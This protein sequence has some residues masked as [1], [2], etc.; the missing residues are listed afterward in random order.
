[1]LRLSSRPFQLLLLASLATAANADEFDTFKIA[2]T[3]QTSVTGVGGEPFPP[4][5]YVGEFTLDGDTMTAFVVGV[6]APCS[7]CTPFPDMTSFWIPSTFSPNPGFQYGRA[8]YDRNSNTLDAFLT[9]Y[10]ELL[11]NELR[12]DLGHRRRRRCL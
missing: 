8:N 1:M 3:A 10:D 4:L 7:Q 2:L 6:D 12:W 11:Q 9:S 5:N